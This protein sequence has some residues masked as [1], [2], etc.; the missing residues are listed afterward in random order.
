MKK[1]NSPTETTSKLDR[2]TIEKNRRIHMKGLC[3]KLASLVPSRHS[4]ET[5]TQQDQLALAASYITHLRERVEKLKA[6]KEQAMKEHHLPSST[7]R[8]SNKRRNDDVFDH[9]TRPIGSLSTKLPMIELKDLGCGIELVLISGL[10]KNFMLYEVI[11]VFEEEGAEVVSASFSV[12]DDKIFHTL[13]AQVKLSRVGVET[14][15]VWQRL[16][17]LI[18]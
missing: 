14:S 2:K 11:S 17:D 16:Q 13:H 6:R 10:Q 18:Y 7:S 3:F 12:V 9:T 8:G 1:I 5:L 15:R 4:K